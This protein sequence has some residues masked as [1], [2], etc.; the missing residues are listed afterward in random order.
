MLIFSN[1]GKSV[2]RLGMADPALASRVRQIP[3]PSVPDDQRDPNLISETIHEPTFQKAL[4]AKL[5]RAGIGLDGPPE[6]PTAVKKATQERLELDLDD[7]DRLAMRFA[8]RA[9]Q[10]GAVLQGHLGR[11][12]RVQW[13]DTVPGSQTESRTVEPA[14]IGSRPAGK[15]RRSAKTQE[16]TLRQW[17]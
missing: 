12:V 17:R 7:I 14:N 6:S 11:L 16:R 15:G 2:P 8:P 3:Y 5:V 13:R 4:L 1:P 9:A 10:S